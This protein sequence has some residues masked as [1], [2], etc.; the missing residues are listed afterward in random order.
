MEN[1]SVALEVPRSVYYAYHALSN[2]L[3]LYDGTFEVRCS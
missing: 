1:V 3:L 2:S